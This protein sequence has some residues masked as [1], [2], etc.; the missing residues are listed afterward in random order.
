VEASKVSATGRGEVWLC[1]VSRAVPISIG[2]GENRGQQ[3]T[4]YNVVRNL[5]KVG[6]WNGGAGSWTIPPENISRDG[7][8]AGGASVLDGYGE[9]PGPMV[10][11]ACRALG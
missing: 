8:D 1:S 2:R 3:I 5:V 7:V 6:D 9:W 11:A 10:A 4:Y